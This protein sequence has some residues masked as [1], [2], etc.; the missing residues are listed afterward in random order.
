MN[1]NLIVAMS[2]APLRLSLRVRY[3][4]LGWLLERARHSRARDALIVRDLL[5]RPTRP[6]DVILIEPPDGAKCY[7]DV[8]LY[9]WAHSSEAPL[10][11]AAVLLDGQAVGH[12][13]L[14][15]GTSPV[16]SRVFRRLAH[17]STFRSRVSLIDKSPGRHQLGIRVTDVRGNRADQTI[18]IIMRNPHPRPTLWARIPRGVL[19]R[20]RGLARSRELKETTVTQQLAAL[21]DQLRHALGRE[22]AMLNWYTDL[23]LGRLFPQAHVFSPPGQ[24]SAAKLLYLDHTIDVVAL[25]R[26]ASD[27]HFQEARRVASS[28]VVSTGR[29]GES[30]GGSES[31]RA[32]KSI[33]VDWHESARAREASTSVSII[34]PVHNHAAYTERCLDQLIKTVPANLAVEVIVVDDAST[35]STAEV[36]T[37][38]ARRDPRVTY[39]RNAANCGFVHS[40][41]D[42]AKHAHGQMLV[43]LNNDTLP[44]PGWL[45]AL[46][47]TFL[48]HPEAGAVG[49]KLVY[50]D[51]T[52]QEAGGVIF[53]DGSGCNV[54]RGAK[55]PNAALYNYTRQ[56]DYCSG[57][58]L[59]TPAVLF[60]DVG[61]FDT[62][63]CPAYYED[64]DYCF[65]VRARGRPVYYQPR[66]VVVHFEGV[67]SGTDTSTGI[68]S[69]QVVNRKKFVKKWRKPLRA[70]PR[71]SAPYTSAIR[72]A[73]SVHGARI[74]SRR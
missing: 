35:D 1:L 34:I 28:L 58:V 48:D 46:L 73:L 29:G 52:L 65:S 7:R 39:V 16:I 32:L 20:S 3:S 31:P 47:D 64:T 45:T 18:S 50:P 69:Y 37:E 12:L 51:G 62:R 33:E 74:L 17:Y 40:C 5:R 42:G 70:Q 27:A 67:T 43:F 53:S 63:F 2:S 57:A 23:D 41:N 72:R 59:A 6:V 60:W 55:N 10:L 30:C 26:E 71:P 22:P 61:G 19:R 56:V 49:A 11:E 44:R 15:L 24:H 38:F 13:P 25:P 66:S 8:L 21:L 36:I 9:G 54:G 14:E 4:K 68:K